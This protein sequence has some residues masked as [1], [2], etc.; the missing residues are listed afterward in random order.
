LRHRRRG[1]K[2]TC[3]DI[4]TDDA[5]RI[6]DNTLAVFDGDYVRRHVTH[7]YAVTV[8]SAQGVTADTAHAVLG[9]NTTR[10]LLYVAM[11]RGRDTNIAYLYERI[12]EH[13]YGRCTTRRSKV[14]TFGWACTAPP[15]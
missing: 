7:G 8:H 2:I 12:A 9:E 1:R 5:R 14:M 4:R 11:T 3:R 10:S 13:E 15:R 6:H